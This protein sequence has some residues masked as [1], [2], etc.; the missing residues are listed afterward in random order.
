[1]PLAESRGDSE[2]ATRYRES[3]EKL[4][5]AF[6]DAGMGWRLYH[7]AYYDDGTPLGASSADECRIGAIAQAWS[8]LPR[9][10]PADRAE[11]T[12]PR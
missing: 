4:G 7:R 5:E 1:M 9:A 11:I 2:R 10:A 3:Q 8:V 6:N 12:L